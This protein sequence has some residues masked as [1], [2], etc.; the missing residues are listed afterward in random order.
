MTTIFYKTLRNYH[1]FKDNKPVHVPQ[2]FLNYAGLPKMMND[3]YRYTPKDT[4][5]VFTQPS[6]SNNTYNTLKRPTTAQPRYKS[7]DHYVQENLQ[8]LE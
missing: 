1:S 7:R 4:D 2:P 8:K 6:T 5:V 3:T